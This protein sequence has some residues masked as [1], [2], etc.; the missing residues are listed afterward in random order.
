M[1]LTKNGIADIVCSNTDIPM[2]QCLEI[3]ESVLEIIKTELAKGNDVMISGFGKWSVKSK[4]A[5]NGRNP[6]TGETIIID[7]R[8]VTT[9]KSASTLRSKLNHGS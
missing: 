1:A 2:H 7:K 6:H 9:F 5:R 8:R 3:V 4:N